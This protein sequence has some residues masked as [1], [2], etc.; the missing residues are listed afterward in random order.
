MVYVNFLSPFFEYF[1]LFYLIKFLALYS[2]NITGENK[3]LAY[4]KVMQIVQ[5]IASTTSVYLAF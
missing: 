5:I 1:F 3:Y 4:Y 2:F